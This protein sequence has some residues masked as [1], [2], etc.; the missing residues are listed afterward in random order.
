MKCAPQKILVPLSVDDAEQVAFAQETVDAACD[1]AAAFGAHL[2]LVYA[3]PPAVPLLG[4]ELSG[5]SY[6]ALKGV[7]EARLEAAL[8]N[9]RTM[10]ERCHARSIGVDTLVTTEPDSVAEVICRTAKEQLVDMILV[11]SHGRRG[12]KRLLMGSVAERIAHLAHVPVLLLK[13]A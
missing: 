4:P 6:R 13:P 9:L 10:E 1:V 11:P 3:A 5:E 7:F 8:Q 2:L 12:V